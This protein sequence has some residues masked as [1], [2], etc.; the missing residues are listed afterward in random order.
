[1]DDFIREYINTGLKVF[2][3]SLCSIIS[4]IVIFIIL[5]FM[6]LISF[7]LSLIASFISGTIVGILSYKAIN[8]IERN[9]IHRKN[10]VFDVLKEFQKMDIS[11]DAHKPTLIM[12]SLAELKDKKIYNY[13]L[14]H[15][16]SYQPL[17]DYWNKSNDLIKDINNKTNNLEKYAFDNINEGIN[18]EYQKILSYPIRFIIKET[19]EKN[20]A[21]PTIRIED[22]T[23]YI[24][25][26]IEENEH[27][28]NNHI[29]IHLK[30][31]DEI[32]IKV[33]LTRL[34]NNIVFRKLT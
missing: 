3:A 5:F 27:M 7:V 22:N 18:D 30:K 33:F 29:S 28:E 19:V 24:Y 10:I 1:M 20:I 34:I 31:L 14:G 21:K 4:F 26:F 13:T 9:K 11:Y 16:A 15:L 17:L 23:N 12:T 8:K 25:I 32:K 2:T 6:L